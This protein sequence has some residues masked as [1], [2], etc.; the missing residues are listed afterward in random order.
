MKAMIDDRIRVCSLVS[1]LFIPLWPNL[2]L[3]IVYRNARIVLFR[4][5]RAFL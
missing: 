5:L 1:K 3:Y 4:Q 2:Q